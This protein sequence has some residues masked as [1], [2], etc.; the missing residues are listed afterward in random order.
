MNTPEWIKPGACVIDVG[1]NRVGE[2]ISEKTGKKIAILK[3]DVDPGDMPGGLWERRGDDLR[4]ACRI[5][6]DHVPAH[7][8]QDLP[9]GNGFSTALA[10]PVTC[11]EVLP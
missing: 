3:G 5:R 8:L 1:V 2:K 7:G 6:E 10:G 9:E 11:R 4:A